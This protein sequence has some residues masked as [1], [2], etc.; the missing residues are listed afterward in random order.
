MCLWRPKMTRKK[1][2]I[3][4]KDINEYWRNGADILM[5]RT[6]YWK[7]IADE[8][9]KNSFVTTWALLPIKIE[10][11]V[12]KRIN[13]IRNL[14]FFLR[15]NNDHLNQSHRFNISRSVALNHSKYFCRE[16]IEWRLM[17]THLDL[18]GSGLWHLGHWLSKRTSNALRSVEVCWG[19][20]SFDT[21][22]S[23]GNSGKRRKAD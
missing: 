13:E 9:R 11:R 7:E 1:F 8:V 2:Q 4:G 17:C 5:R 16:C 12:C 20:D 15:R 21:A 10:Y 23:S 14:F 22:V 19:C 3:N 18:D 6:K